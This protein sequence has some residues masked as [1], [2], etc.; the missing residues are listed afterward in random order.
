M[1]HAPWDQLHI[2]IS[3]LI[4]ERLDLEDRIRFNLVCKQWSKNTKQ[5]PQPLWLML[6]YEPNNKYLNFFDMCDG[7][8]RKLNLP[9]SVQGGWFCGCSKGWLFLALG[10]TL[11]NLQ[12]FLFDPI[13][14]VQIPLPPL[15]TI[16]INFEECFSNCRSE[17]NLAAC[18]IKEVEPSSSDVSQCIV[19]ATLS[20]KDK[21]LAL[22]RPGD[23]RWTIVKGLLVEGYFYGSI[24]FFDGELY[25]SIANL[26]EEYDNNQAPLQIHSIMIGSQRVNLKLIY[27]TFPPPFLFYA[28]EADET[29]LYHKDCIRFSWMVESNGQLLM[30]TQT[31]DAITTGIAIQEEEEEEDQSPL[32]YNQAATFQVFKIQKTT[33]DTVCITSLADLGNQ[34]LFLG[35]GSCVAREN[36]NQFHKNC[37]YFLQVFDYRDRGDKICPYVCREAGVYHLDDGS[38]KRCFPSIQTKISSFMHW[39]S[40]N[41]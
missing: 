28:Q 36:L 10:T 24:I 30:V 23:E 33:Q 19:A 16:S 4:F 1:V 14:R 29:L 34:S 40:P 7:K 38:I 26:K 9:E 27:S 15:S 18:I 25:A 3:G 5:T 11:D 20:D 12:S 22:C 32:E 17:W 41:I 2:S 35:V 21:T 37:I 6:P 39:F 13:T 8:V 31:W